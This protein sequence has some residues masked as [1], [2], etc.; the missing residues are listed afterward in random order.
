HTR[1]S[2]D[3]SSDV[4]SS[5]LPLAR[6]L[7]ARL[8]DHG[9]ETL[10]RRARLGGHDLTEEGPRDPLGLPAALAHLARA[11]RG[12]GPAARALA[13]R[14]HDGR[15]DLDL[16]VRPEGRLGKVDLDAHERVLPA[17]GARDWAA[18]RPAGRGPEE[19]LEDVLEPEGRD[20]K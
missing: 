14:A 1:F 16:A 20:R 5:D 3:W 7:G 15:V 18:R 2:R 13:R 19:R 10:A 9:P 4:C 11:R 17:P 6:A 8:G 12:A